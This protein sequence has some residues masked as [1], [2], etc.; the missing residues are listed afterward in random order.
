MLEQPDTWNRTFQKISQIEDVCKWKRTVLKGSSGYTRSE[1][2][3]FQPNMWFS[4]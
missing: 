3:K 2:P 4:V 1:R